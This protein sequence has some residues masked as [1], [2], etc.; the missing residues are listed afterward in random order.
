MKRRRMNMTTIDDDFDADRAKID[1]L[2]E[3]ASEHDATPEVMIMA[4]AF[5]LGVTTANNSESELK[6]QVE[7]ARTILDE[8][9]ETGRIAE[10]ERSR[11]EEMT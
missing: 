4:A 10:L 7:L 5:W 9:A 3:W 6:K 1:A 8:F 11:R 2:I